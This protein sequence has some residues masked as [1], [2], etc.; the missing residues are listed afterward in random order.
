MQ[1]QRQKIA[2]LDAG[3]RTAKPDRFTPLLAVIRNGLGDHW[4]FYEECIQGILEGA[5]KQQDTTAWTE[6]MEKLVHGIKDVQI[7]HEGIVF[8][9]QDLGVH[10]PK[11]QGWSDTDEDTGKLTSPTLSPPQH[12]MGPIPSC[13]ANIILLPSSPTM[14]SLLTLRSLR[15]TTPAIA[16]WPAPTPRPQPHQPRVLRD[17]VLPFDFSA[18]ILPALTF[19]KNLRAYH[20]PPETITMNVRDVLPPPL[21]LRESSKDP[22]FYSDAVLRAEVAKS[23]GCASRSADNGQIGGDSVWQRDQRL[24]YEAG[25]DGLVAWRMQEEYG[26]QGESDKAKADKTGTWPPWNFRIDLEL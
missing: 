14:T 19:P 4:T 23:F 6:Q 12:H 8:L 9:L 3:F 5:T 22:V 17:G 18:C 2:A 1:S 7:S 24:P 26:T 11:R 25:D 10:P 16:E 20:Y 21:P 13:K 15:P